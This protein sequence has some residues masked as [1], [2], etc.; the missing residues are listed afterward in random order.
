MTVGGLLFVDGDKI[1]H[2]TAASAGALLS[3]D[4]Q[5]A[6]EESTEERNSEDGDS[7]TDMREAAEKRSSKAIFHVNVNLDAS[8]DSDKL[9]KHLA[10][11]KRY[12]AI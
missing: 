1:S 2:K 12:G 7:L 11:L 3:G 9:E 6:N 10:L 4:E 5:D 8:L